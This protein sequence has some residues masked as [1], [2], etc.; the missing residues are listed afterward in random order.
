MCRYKINK[1]VW[2][3]KN[4]MDI[5]CLKDDVARKNVTARRDDEL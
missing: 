1:L 5:N 2:D 4:I 3:H